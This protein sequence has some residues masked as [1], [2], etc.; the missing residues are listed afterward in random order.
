MTQSSVSFMHMFNAYIT[1]VAR[2]RSLANI[3]EEELHRRKQHHIHCIIVIY[4]YFTFHE[5]PFNCFLAMTH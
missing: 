3:L 1:S 5:A 4:I 2:F